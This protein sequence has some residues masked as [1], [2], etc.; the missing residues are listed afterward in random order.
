MVSREKELNTRFMQWKHVSKRICA[1]LLKFLLF[2][3]KSPKDTWN[4]YLT[5]VNS[6]QTACMHRLI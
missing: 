3:C 6:D 4:T 2:T 1:K 5:T